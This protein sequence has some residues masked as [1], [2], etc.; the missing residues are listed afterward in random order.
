MAT[1]PGVATFALILILFSPAAM[2]A[3]RGDPL[4]PSEG[5]TLRRGGAGGGSG[6]SASNEHYEEIPT[7]TTLQ[8]GG[9]TTALEAFGGGVPLAAQTNDPGCIPGTLLGSACWKMCG[10][11]PNGHR[12]VETVS[13]NVNPPNFARFMDPVEV[14]ADQKPVRVCYRVKNWSQN[15]TKGY[16]VVLQHEPATDSVASGAR[17]S[18]GRNEI[19]ASHDVAGDLQPI[20]PWLIGGGGVLVGAALTLAL[21][22]R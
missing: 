17:T 6:A 12:F 9:T 21:K 19:S 22:R 18:V 15:S 20:S 16:R 3:Q 7:T 2:F 14:Y 11:L 1:R 10:P 8:P 4:N 5:G 13:R